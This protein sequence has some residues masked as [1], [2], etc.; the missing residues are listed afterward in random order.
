LHSDEAFILHPT[1]N[2][3]FTEIVNFPVAVTNHSFIHII[4]LL[5]QHIHIGHINEMYMHI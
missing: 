5:Y 2:I 1:T 3:T 4:N